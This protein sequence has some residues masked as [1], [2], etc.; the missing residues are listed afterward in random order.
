MASV[1][2]LD[3]RAQLERLLGT[4]Y[5]RG[6]N[7]RRRLL[8]FLV[9]QW[10][11][12]EGKNISA[13][14]IAESLKIETLTFEESS[15]KHGFPRTR[16]NLAHV[17]RFL[18]KH[19]DTDGYRDPVILKLN[20]G[21]YLPVIAANPVSSAMPD[22]DPAT[23]RLTLRA[24]TAIDTRTARGGLR[25]FE[26]FL[27]V[28]APS[29]NP[30]Q[31]ANSCFILMASAAI[32]PGLP[33]D[34][35]LAIEARI[36]RIKASGVEPWE[37]TFAEASIE[38]CHRHDW[39]KSL[40]LFELAVE[41]SQGEAKFFWW[42]TALLAS[43]GQMQK[44]I[45]ILAS[46]V[47]HFSRTSIAVRTDLALLQVMAGRFEDA[48]E[49]LSGSLDFA[50]ES[51]LP[52]L[53]ARM[54]LLEAQ[55]RMNEADAIVTRLG[56]AM[57]QD[58]AHSI[59]TGIESMQEDELS[60][61]RLEEMSSV[62]E[63]H[64]LFAGVFALILARV[65]QTDLAS[66]VVELLLAAK[67]KGPEMSSVAIAIGMVGLGR[68]DDAVSW[69]RKAAFDESDPLAMWFH[70]FPPLRHLRKHRGYRQLLKDLGLS[71]QRDR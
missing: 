69:L 5:F 3:V 50:P 27:K 43:T 26:Y 65:N 47:R 39:K 1:D 2:P 6:S 36:A 52:I 21:S 60:P 7:T 4:R 34:F 17:R 32:F 22:L 57:D 23:E 58:A 70:I 18:K 64:F 30:R 20:S 29:D 35:R 55:D 28:S 25:A 63:G 10:L 42:Y 49:I 61:S 9:E 54:V 13:R 31:E 59:V 24:K 44:A 51:N 15:D 67:A 16:A 38:A 14:F 48:E 62:S 56:D 41:R 19:Y 53:Y 68:F 66:Q 45:D 8:A 12:D 71:L 11:F 33:T 46:A 37:C 40:D